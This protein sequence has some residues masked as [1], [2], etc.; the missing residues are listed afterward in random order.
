M[1]SEQETRLFL[2]TLKLKKE[3]NKKWKKDR[4]VDIKLFIVIIAVHVIMLLLVL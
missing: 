2:E 1:T 4:V 3:L